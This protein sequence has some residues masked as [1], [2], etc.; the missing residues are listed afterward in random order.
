[1]LHRGLISLSKHKAEEPT[2]NKATSHLAFQP[3][4]PAELATSLEKKN[5][6]HL[7]KNV[8]KV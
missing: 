5:A 3:P 4:N 1:M 6:V 7:G 2:P 8:S